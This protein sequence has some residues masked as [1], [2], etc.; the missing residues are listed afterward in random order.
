MNEITGWNQANHLQYSSVCYGKGGWV[1]FSTNGLTSD[2]QK[3]LRYHKFAQDYMYRICLT[4]ICLM[5]IHNCIS[6]YTPAGHLSALLHPGNL[7][8]NFCVFSFDI[9]LNEILSLQM[10]CPF[11]STWIARMDNTRCLILITCKAVPYQC[12]T[13]S[14]NTMIITMAPRYLMSLLKKRY[15][16]II[17]HR[18]VEFLMVV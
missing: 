6:N 11:L 8:Y 1:N 17:V 18:S 3:P 7:I 9:F 12:L 10:C 2:F 5:F 14:F 15:S 13:I 4:W 16:R